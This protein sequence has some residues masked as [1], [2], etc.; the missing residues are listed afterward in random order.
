[1]LRPSAVLNPVPT[2]LA[3]IIVVMCAGSLATCLAACLARARWINESRMVPRENSA[4]T[5]PQ[6]PQDDSE[7]LR[8]IGELQHLDTGCN[9]HPDRIFDMEWSP[10]AA[11]ECEY[12]ASASQVRSFTEVCF[13][14]TSAHTGR[15]LPSLAYWCGRCT[16]WRWGGRMPP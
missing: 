8:V 16:N 15:Y 3:L 7:P 12:L 5:L 13:H 2:K 11:L 4:K 10:A 9:A 6:Q 14:C 1:M